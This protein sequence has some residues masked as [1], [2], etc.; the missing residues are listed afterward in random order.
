MAAYLVRCCLVRL[1]EADAGSEFIRML[2]HCKQCVPP[3]AARQV[4]ER[5]GWGSD[6]GCGSSW[7]P[8]SISCRAPII[9]ALAIQAMIPCVPLLLVQMLS[10]LLLLS[11]GACHCPHGLATILL[12]HSPTPVVLL[13]PD[14]CREG[15][16][17]G[18]YCN[19]VMSERSSQYTML[20]PYCLGQQIPVGERVHSKSGA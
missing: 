7:L 19:G 16:A 3:C 4:P 12:L 18:S 15:L 8:D 14:I 1:T 17:P 6:A 9:P 5:N 2:R 11:V 10:S 20:H 13:N